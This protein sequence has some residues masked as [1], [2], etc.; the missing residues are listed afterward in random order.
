MSSTSVG[1]L[2]SAAGQS[3][4]NT[5]TGAFTGFN[6]ILK[7]Y[8]EGPLRDLI[9]STRILA[10]VI[11][12]DVA[13][14]EVMG[15]MVTLGLRTGRNVGFKYSREYA[16]IVAP[17]KQGTRQA[18][19]RTRS[20]YGTASFTGQ[21]VAAARSSPGAFINLMDLEINGIAE[22]AQHGE[23]RTYYSDGSGALARI[24][25]KAVAGGVSVLTLDAPGGIISQ[26]LGTQYLEVGMRI[27]I[28]KAAA[29]AEAIMAST[30]T[31]WVQD[32]AATVRSFTITAIDYS[33]GTITLDFNID[34]EA[35]AGQYLY[36]AQRGSIPVA[37]FQDAHTNR[38]AEMNGL[39]SIISDAN[40]RLQR[41]TLPDPEP[42]VGFGNIDVGVEPLWKAYVLSNGGVPVPWQSSFFDDALNGLAQAG[43]GVVKM[44]LTTFGIRSQF[45][46]ELV[47]QRRYP[48]TLDLGGGYRAVSWNGIPII[49]DKD[50]IRGTVFGIDTSTL[51]LAKMSDW[52]FVDNHGLVMDRIPGYDAFIV[53]LRRY[54][55]FVCN[56]R[57]RNCVI[58][59]IIDV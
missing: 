43:N 10:H 1:L 56:A 20:N 28:A 26:A 7:R 36:V 41:S 15:E 17:G 48:D 57:N 51:G 27:A 53:T 13:G 12:Q 24:A 58:K 25:A 55:E 14:I 21:G 54:A 40:P 47:A 8:Y 30:N 32:N 46:A 19:W 11:N 34:N 18:R 33:A 39:S 50:C 4:F 38:G 52:E 22:D 45:A 6:N 59:D 31:N 2:N 37:E 35:L 49:V 23:Q 9:N 29:E 16:P 44:W 42:Y 5:S 3:L